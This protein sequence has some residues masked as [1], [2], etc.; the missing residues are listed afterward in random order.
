VCKELTAYYILPEKCERGCEHC[1]LACPVEAIGSTEKGIK[2]ID[3]TK[4]TKCG[5]CELVCPPEYNAVVRLSPVSSVPSP[6]VKKPK[7]RHKKGTK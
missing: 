4:C 5:S 6:E 3:Q 7:K 2:V 1:V